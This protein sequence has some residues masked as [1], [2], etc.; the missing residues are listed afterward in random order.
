MISVRNLTKRYHDVVA[1]DN[2][3]FDVPRGAVMGFLGPNGAGKTTTLRILAGYIPATEG[4]AEIDGL[5]VARDSMDVRSRI[6]YLPENVP[7][8]GEMRVEEYLVFRGRLK[9]LSRKAAQRR[10]EEVLGLCG[11]ADMRRRIVGQL[12]KGYRQRVGLADALLSQPPVLIL[13]EPTA[14]LDPAQRKQVRELIRGLG[15]EQTILL[16]SHILGEV[17]SISDRVMIIKGGELLAQGTLAELNQQLGQKRRLSIE[18]AWDR[19]QLE[20]VLTTIE[21]LTREE[22]HAL[23]DGFHAHTLAVADGVDPREKLVATFAREGARLRELR[24]A[25]ASLEETF[26]RLTAE[27]AMEETTPSAGGSA[28]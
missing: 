27:A 5:D 20:A 17:E 6:G 10:V 4:T 22:S 7:L 2:I 21:G 23:G 19:T 18:I 1:V 24:W 8:Y 9:G 25:S 28:P 14:G 11:L 13:D 3:S 12:S 16:S 26:L 15:E